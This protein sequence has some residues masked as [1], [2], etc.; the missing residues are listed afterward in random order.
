MTKPLVSVVMPVFNAEATLRRAIDSVLQQSHVELELL[1]VDDGS[2]DASWTLLKAYAAADR[3]VRS[4]QAASNGG[5]AAARNLAL[6][7]AAGQF[8][9]FLDSDDWWHP[10]KLE[11][12]VASMRSTGAKISYASYRRVAEDGSVLSDVLPPARVR[13]DDMLKSNHIGNLTGMYERDAPAVAGTRAAANPNYA[14]WNSQRNWDVQEKLKA[15][16]QSR[17]W[18]LPQMSLAWLLSRPAIS[19][20]IAGAD[21][22]EHI[23]EN[24]KALEIR[25]TLE[26]LT[27]IDRLTLVD[28]DRSVAPV[29][30]KLRP[31]KVH[32][33]EPM[34]AAKARGLLD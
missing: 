20:V 21:K 1:A 16:A 23:A 2:R 6:D 12:Q 10:R 9:A 27:E 11:L 32:E 26:D 24:I 3:R 28:E 17:G 13:H 8:V 30:R 14:A 5:V 22:P 19:T 31:E 29:Y 4:L 15:F 18:T 33:F 34:Q 7:A 25:L